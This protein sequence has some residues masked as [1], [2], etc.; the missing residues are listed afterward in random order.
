MAR[1]RLFLHISSAYANGNRPSGSTVEERIYPLGFGDSQLPHARLAAELS[2]MPPAA[3]DARAAT[4]ARLW[5][6]PGAPSSTPSSPPPDFPSLSS[7]L[8]L[9]S[10]SSI[11]AA[12]AAHIATPTAQAVLK[13][14][15]PPPPAAPAGT[16]CL[17]KN[18]AEKL[19]AEVHGC[20]RLRCAIVRPSIVSCVSGEP[21]PGAHA[22]RQ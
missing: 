14:H 20:G 16:Y 15:H 8:S 11:A 1:A 3:A 7:A 13:P 2:L 19:V 5:G 18:M 12:A 17:A 4:L 10:P 22:M 9:L 6:F 21:Y